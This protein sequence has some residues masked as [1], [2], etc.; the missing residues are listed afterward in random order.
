MVYEIIPASHSNGTTTS[1]DFSDTSIRRFLPNG[2]QYQY[3]IMKF[4]SPNGQTLDGIGHIP[5]ITIKNEEANI[6]AGEDLVLERAIEYIEDMG[7]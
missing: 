6:Q 2:W 1:G 3:S 7:L 4:L 5:N